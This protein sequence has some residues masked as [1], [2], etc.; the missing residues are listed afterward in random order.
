M[1]FREFLVATGNSAYVKSMERG[2]WEIVAYVRDRLMALLRTYYF[3]GGMPEAVAS[4]VGGEGMEAVRRIQ[5]DI[6]ST[7]EAD[8][9]KHAPAVEVP[10]IRLVWHSIVSQLA[11][12]NRKYV[13]GLLR[14]GARAKDFEMAIE[15]LSDAGMIRRVPRVKSGELPL[16][17]YEDF[18]SFKLF[19]LDVG[20]MAASNKLP[21]TSLL[22]GNELLTTFRGA[23]TEQYVCQ[24]LSGRSDGVYYW[25]AD[26]SRGEIDFLVQSRGR[27]VPIEV[28]AEENLRSKSLAAFV[29]R[30]PSLHALRFSMSDY[31]CQEWM[32]NVPL[33]AVGICAV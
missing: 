24:Q 10:R 8:F 13:Y 19:M 5:T 9:S 7:Y 18:G 26:N 31:R 29:K 25:S 28:K 23:L 33:Y 4:Y 11:K 20:L 12:E 6:L 1:T 32:T 30:Y 14:H 22:S 15:W 2:E 17:A 3:V 27:V 16:G 21:A